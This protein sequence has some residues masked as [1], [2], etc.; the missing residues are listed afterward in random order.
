[1]K[2]R[3]LSAMRADSIPAGDAGLW[4]VRKRVISGED[5]FKIAIKHG[6][7]CCPGSY[8]FL[9]RLTN[10][11][12]MN[13]AF[14]GEVVMNDMPCELRTHLDFCMKAKGKILVGGLGLGCVVRGLLV[15]DNVTSIDV[16]ERDKNVIKLCG[17]S[18]AH[19]KVTI[20][21]GDAWEDEIAGG[22]WD[23]IWWDLWS[24]KDNDEPALSLVHMR[25]IHK[26]R[27]RCK[28]QGAWAFPRKYR[29]SLRAKGVL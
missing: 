16:I 20:H 2:D 4:F 17:D 5:A 1:M 15:N 9:Y 13:S 6:R 12:L 18:I 11:S 24:D 3:I 23:K 25:L 22:P 27:K 7:E 14:P 29:R 10:D 19:P 26:F 21:W 28:K 8:T